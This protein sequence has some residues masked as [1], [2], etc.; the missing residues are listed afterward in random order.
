[1]RVSGVFVCIGFGVSV[2]LCARLSVCAVCAREC[3]LWVGGGRR[4]KPRE[5]KDGAILSEAFFSVV[6]PFP[7][8]P[9]I[10]ASTEI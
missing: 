4:T 9:W 6:M 10:D 1:M 2:R 8:S 3:V 5:Y 7:I